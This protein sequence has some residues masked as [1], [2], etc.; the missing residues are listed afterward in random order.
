[1]A[2]SSQGSVLDAQ[3]E[4]KN[5]A[6]EFEALM[7]QKASSVG[8]IVGKNVLVSLTE[9]NTFTQDYTRF[10]FL[11][12]RLSPLLGQRG[13]SQSYSDTLPFLLAE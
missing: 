5:E 1:M 4:A 11:S 13:P 6:N 2:C 9:A 8:S 10:K 7:C 12:L 3:V